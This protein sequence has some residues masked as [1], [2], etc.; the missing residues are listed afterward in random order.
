MTQNVQKSLNDKNT[1]KTFDILKSIESII[2]SQE[3]IK[4]AQKE[5]E[6]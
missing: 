6:K 2:N 4:K 1:A 3:I 5:G